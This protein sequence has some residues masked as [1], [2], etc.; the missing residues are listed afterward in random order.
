MGHL[1][2]PR[3]RTSAGPF[4]TSVAFEFETKKNEL[5]AADELN[6]I[7]VRRLV[8]PL[9]GTHVMMDD[10]LCPAKRHLSNPPIRKLKAD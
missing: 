6:P 8:Q 4:L 3:A 5:V 9:G 1:P 10:P 7:K 2:M